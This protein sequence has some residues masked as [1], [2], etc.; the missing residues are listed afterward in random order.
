MKVIIGMATFAGRESACETAVESLAKQV[1]D[2]LLWDNSTEGAEDLT[3]NGKFAGLSMIDE[4]C[5]YL[6]CDDDL[7]YPEDYVEQM[8][9]AIERT[10]SIVTHHGRI[11]TGLNKNYYTG[12]ESFR[13]LDDVNIERRIDVCGTGVTGFKTSAFNPVH[14]PYSKDKKMSDL[15]FSCAAVHHGIDIFVQPH[16]KGWIKQLDIDHKT[17]IYSTEKHK[18]TRQ[19]EIANEIYS[20][21]Y[22]T[23]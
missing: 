13:C 2:I 11:L 23:H 6:T 1:D 5:Y 14:L 17:S 8:L 7:L 15:I 3:D 20:L 4:D 19:A 9:E 16:R 21:R 10:N 12:H 22:E 18:A